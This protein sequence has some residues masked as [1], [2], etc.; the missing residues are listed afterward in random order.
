[1]N[2]WFDERTLARSAAYH[3]PLLAVGLAG[4]LTSLAA[5]A[6]LAVACGPAPG[7][8]PASRALSLGALAA[9]AQ[10]GAGLPVGLW[11]ELRHEPGHA[12]PFDDAPPSLD[13]PPL[14]DAPSEAPAS[15]APRSEAMRSG[16]R[17]S[18][19]AGGVGATGAGPAPTGRGLGRS[20]SGLV[21]GPVV[22]V[23]VV[24]DRVV[25]ALGVAAS[26]AAMV[27]VGSAW[28]A[29]PPLVGLL[30]IPLLVAAGAPAARRLAVAGRRRTDRVEPLTSS[31]WL[32]R[33]DALATAAAAQSGRG[34][35]PE[36]RWWVGS[37]RLRLTGERA[38]VH[39]G[40]RSVDVVLDRTLLELPGPDAALAVAAHELGHV[41]AMPQGPLAGIARLAA[42]AAAAAG[43]AALLRLTAGGPSGWRDGIGAVHLGAAAVLFVL[44]SPLLAARRRAEERRADAV[45]AR[46]LPSPA[47]VAVR[48]LLLDAGVELE[49]GPLAR[50][51][52]GYPPPAERLD[53]LA[54]ACAPRLT[55]PTARRP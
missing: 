3:R 53:V 6:G 2:R 50:L 45:A 34:S 47:V 48:R 8:S 25:A 51:L 1:M 7:A 52:S 28:A 33:L 16:D 10:L 54:A 43:L 23:V 5:F 31:L 19:G 29:A 26:V 12:P 36:L 13:A 38:W 40:R 42:P 46:L 22:A 21:G 41:S 14:D 24:L 49:P 11:R 27:V 35:R 20:R 9:L 37:G 17:P 18:V 32:A 30:T 39:P 44:V 55:A 4:A 15:E